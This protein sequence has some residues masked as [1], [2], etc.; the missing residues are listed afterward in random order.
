MTASAEPMM[1]AGEI[2]L[3]GDRRRLARVAIV[4]LS[5]LAAGAALLS[6]A[7]G[8]TGFI[9]GR[10]LSIL[11]S[12]LVGNTDAVDRDTLVVLEIRLPRVAFSLL[13]GAALATSGCVMR[14]LFRNPL[15]DPGL[16]GISSGA[17]L[18]AVLTIVLGGPFV[19]ALPTLPR[20]YA[21]PAAAFI[22]AL[23]A[24]ALLYAIATRAGR[25]SIATMLLAGIAIAALA[26]AATGILIFISDDRQLRDITFWSLGT[27][28]GAT[29]E[30]AGVLLPFVGLALIV[31]ARFSGDLDAMLLGEAE[32]AHLGVEVEKLK[33]AAIVAV[34]AGVGASVAFTGIIGFLGIVVPHLLRLA[35][36]PTHRGLLPAS[37]F[38]GA[39]LFTLADTAYRV[40]V[41]PAELPIGILTALFGAPFFLWLL[42]RRRGIVDL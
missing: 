32:A 29:F 25:T 36:G 5:V 9:P 39:A 1:A 20:L 26:A 4:A 30:K 27:L 11:G 6:V 7:S 33:R 37:A 41:A 42:L 3:A 22:G 35:I 15:A 40:V 28:G 31:F 13:I 18:A 8:P 10:A 17:A 21:L 2:G 34:A 19:A 16:I 14:S 23:A 12:A 24:T 38:F